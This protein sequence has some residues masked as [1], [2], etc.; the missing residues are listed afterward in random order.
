MTQP[1]GPPTSFQLR[2]YCNS[3]RPKTYEI[4]QGN[5]ISYDIPQALPP[6]CDKITISTYLWSCFLH[7]W[8]HEY[9]SCVLLVYD[10]NLSF[11]YVQLHI[12]VMASLL[13]VNINGIPVM[14]AVFQR[15]VSIK[16]SDY[17]PTRVEK[18]SLLLSTIKTDVFHTLFYSILCYYLATFR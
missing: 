9:S 10:F 15:P 2:P 8:F 6:S 4:S 12:D 18:C 16:R 7:Y 17:D 3:S 1:K 11:L 13:F 14:Y 5:T